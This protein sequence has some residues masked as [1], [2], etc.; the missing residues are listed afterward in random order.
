MPH[1]GFRHTDESKR[2]MSLSNKGRKQSAETVAKRIATKRSLGCQG[3]PKGKPRSEETRQKISLGMKA[4][5]KRQQWPITR[6]SEQRRI[7]HSVKMTGRVPTTDHRAKLSQALTGIIRGPM[8]PEHRRKIAL[9]NRGKGN[10]FPNRRFYYRG[11]PF[12]SSW[13]MQ[14]AQAFDQRGIMW[15]WEAYYFPL[16]ET[17]GYRPDFYLPDL[18][19]YWEVKG[20]LGPQ[21]KRTINSFREQYPEI[22]LIVATE[23][24]IKHLDPEF[25]PRPR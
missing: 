21:A 12:R 8:S 3:W 17:T 20:W 9:A 25:N 10:K 11:I 7:N 6:W 4:A 23:A 5:R 19:C 13:E 22:S 18:D 14:V 15:E 16:T 2:K 24:V 1:K